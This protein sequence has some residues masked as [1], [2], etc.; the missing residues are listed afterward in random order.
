LFNSASIELSNQRDNY[1]IQVQHTGLAT[2]SFPDIYQ[3]Y[4]SVNVR[5]FPFDKQLCTLELQS[6]SRTK[7]ELVVV[8]DVLLNSDQKRQINFIETEWKLEGIHVDT[9]EENNFV[10]LEYKLSLK[11]NHIF[12][13]V[14]MIFPF[15]I[16]SSLS[17]LYYLIKRKE[18]K[19][20]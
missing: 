12:Y 15:F 20:K 11:R 8:N 14:H 10:W 9:K 4:C 19:R 2:W 6:W 17:E 3:S 16:L 1:L 13:V 18:R 7:Q 5:H